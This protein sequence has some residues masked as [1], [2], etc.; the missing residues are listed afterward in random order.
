M[1][2][3]Q[4]G[5]DAGIKVMRAERDAAVARADR[6]ETALHESEQR[7]ADMARLGQIPEWVAEAAAD[8][9]EPNGSV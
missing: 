8:K 1:S 9:E 7:I 3:W 4:E 6:L 2:R 5:Y